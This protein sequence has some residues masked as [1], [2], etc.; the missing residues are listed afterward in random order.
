MSSQDTVKATKFTRKE[1]T[2]RPLIKDCVGTARKFLDDI[3][4][5][6]EGS[7]IF[8]SMG[9]S[10]NSSYLLAGI[11]G[12]GK[13]FSLKALNNEYNQ[14]AVDVDPQKLY[15][16]LWGHNEELP[17]EQQGSKKEV[18]K[19]ARDIYS[20]NY[21]LNMLE[22][23]IGDHGTAYI[24]IGSRI[25]QKFFDTAIHQ[26]K[27]GKS[28]VMVFDEADQIMR[29]RGQGGHGEDDKLISTLMK[30]LQEVQD[31]PNIFT[32]F[33]TNFPKSM[34]SASIRAG[35]I[36]KRYNFEMPTYS[37]RKQL[38][39]SVIRQRND[40]AGYAVVRKYD[41]EK[42]ADATD[43]FSNADIDQVIKEAIR[44]RA[45]EIVRERKDKLIPAGYVTDKRILKACE[46]H[47]ERFKLKRNTIG[48]N[49]Q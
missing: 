27:E 42:I 9:V 43:G 12:T 17:T 4:T 5:S 30:N 37:E 26:A 1:P 44:K 36:D 35:R 29:K 46:K 2:Q 38:I 48:F 8:D 31:I 15:E 21:Q 7:G 33:L 49:D 3:T 32:V 10:P 39:E 14:H 34:D 41:V 18:L 40:D 24:N 22:Y 23:R 11:A 19:Q 20:E 6:I 45:R 13:T 47:R 28:T 16:S 25:L